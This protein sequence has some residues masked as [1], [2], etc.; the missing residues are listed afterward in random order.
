M[1]AT[2]SPSD[3]Q[4]GGLM[5]IMFSFRRAGGRVNVVNA[6]PQAGRREG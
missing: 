4:E 5:L 3:R 2:P 6:S 1:S